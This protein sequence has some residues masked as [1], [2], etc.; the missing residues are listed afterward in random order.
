MKNLVKISPFIAVLNTA[1]VAL[2][3][4]IKLGE[5]NILEMPVITQFRKHDLPV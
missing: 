1:S 3:F 2:S 4:I 5:E